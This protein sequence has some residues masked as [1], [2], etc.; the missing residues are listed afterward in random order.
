MI[1]DS[2]GQ[3]YIQWTEVVWLTL[4]ILVLC[5]SF[6]G[7]SIGDAFNPRSKDKPQRAQQYEGPKLS[8]EHGPLRMK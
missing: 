1:S 2:A 8:T 5:F 3:M 4:A 7:D 6:I